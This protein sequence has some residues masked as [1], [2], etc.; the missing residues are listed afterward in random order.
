M[1]ALIESGPQLRA[2]SPWPRVASLG[3]HGLL[4]GAAIAATS[5]VVDAPHYVPPR[6]D[7]FW[8]APVTQPPGVTAPSPHTP[9]ALV[10]T[11][12]LPTV[13][14]TVPVD[15]P[16]PGTEPVDPGWTADPPGGSPTIAPVAGVPGGGG[17]PGAPI[18]ARYVEEPPVLLTHPALRYP[19][20]LRQAGIEGRVMVEA[21]IDTLGR[22]EPGSLR[23]L[24]GAQSLFEREALAVVVGSRYRPGRVDGRAVRVRVQVPVNFALRR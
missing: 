23:V 18:D 12:P 19:E 17:L 1:F 8:D 11:I 9:D 16:L 20:I 15:I 13:P 21:V 7:I 24:T 4:I 14:V 2:V 22:A 3:V 10:P 5:G 6:I